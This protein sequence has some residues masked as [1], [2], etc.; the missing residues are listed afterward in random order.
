MGRACSGRNRGTDTLRQGHHP[1]A[2]THSSLGSAGSASTE[3]RG[4]RVPGTGQDLGGEAVAGPHT[5]AG[6]SLGEYPT[7]QTEVSCPHSGSPGGGQLAQP[8]LPTDGPESGLV[9]GYHL[10]TGREALVSQALSLVGETR[11]PARGLLFHSDQG[12]QYRSQEYQHYLKRQQ[13][14]PSIQKYL[15]TT[16]FHGQTVTGSCSIPCRLLQL[17]LIYP[18]VGKGK[19]LAL[20]PKP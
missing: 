19:S 2:A 1:R 4:R 13:I 9:W 16:W 15:T 10:S 18:S 17:F 3:S 8:R 6:L 12:A 14:S 11:Q 20:F 5:H 7:Q